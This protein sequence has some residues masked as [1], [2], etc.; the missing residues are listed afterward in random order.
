MLRV[1]VCTYIRSQLHNAAVYGSSV[2]L[3]GP[4]SSITTVSP[5][6][7]I[8][9]SSLRVVTQTLACTPVSERLS[10][11]VSALCSG[12]VHVRELTRSIAHVA[13]YVYSTLCVELTGG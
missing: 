12:V 3:S 5:R 7:I 10:V 6:P 13:L 2:G 9:G 4:V 8:T 1:T 11:C